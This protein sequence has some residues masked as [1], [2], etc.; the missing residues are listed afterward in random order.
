MISSSFDSPPQSCG[1]RCEQ[2]QRSPWP[3]ATAMT[4][5]P[6]CDGETGGSKQE[7]MSLTRQSEA[8][9]KRGKSGRGSG[10]GETGLRYTSSPG[11]PAGVWKHRQVPSIDDEPS[12]GTRVAAPR[13][14][15][16]R[17]VTRRTQRLEQGPTQPPRT[18]A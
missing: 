16:S 5:W 3:P 8:Q 14:Q 6:T 4:A 7:S 9:M 15:D 1:N 10:A 17:T 11:R 2:R 12:A 18:L 13:S